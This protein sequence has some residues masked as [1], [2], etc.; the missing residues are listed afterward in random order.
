M[1]SNASTVAWIVKQISG[2]GEIK[3][4]KM[5]GEYGIYCDDKI[6]AL[7]CDD[8]FF[9]K[10][11]ETGYAFWGEHEEAPPYKGAKALM[12]LS[13]DEMGN[14]ARLV[15][16]ISITHKHLPAQKKLRCAK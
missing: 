13:E 16:L 7:V 4:L 1:A 11:T 5:F 12:V 6:V 15:E 10:R 9:V 8:Q 2:A 3:A 14:K